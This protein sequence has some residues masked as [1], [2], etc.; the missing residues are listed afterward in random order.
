MTKAFTKRRDAY[1]KLTKTLNR[2]PNGFPTTK[3]GTHIRVLQWIFEPDEAELASKMKLSGE[4]IEKMSKRL[5]IPEDELAAKLKIMRE[6]GQIL[7]RRSKGKEKYGL[8]PFV[9]GIYE[10]QIHRMDSEFAHLFEEYVQKTRGDILFTS[11]PPIQRVVPVNKVIK[12]ELEIHPYDKAENMV[13][14]AKSWGIRECICK[15]QKDFLGEPCTYPI[16]VCMT[17]S[18]RKNAYENSSKTKPITMER[19]LE[20]LKETE[21][22]GLI[23]TSMNVQEGHKYICNCCTCCCGILRAVTEWDRP[24]AMVKSDYEISVDEE[25]CIGCGKCIERCQFNALEIIDGKCTVNDKCI[26]CGVCALVCPE[27]AL[28][29]IH[30]DSSEIEEPPKNL[31]KWMLK[32]AFSRRVNLLKLI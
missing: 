19:A 20:I 13:R 5:K 12:T 26:G 11:N 30:R 23:H 15:K 28:S 1:H 24:R 22:A 3:D 4:T 10:E 29:L 2:I 18:S 31:I 17:F 25:S 16:E 27:E 7:I 6:K 21:E 8:L 32:R 9:I 14:Q